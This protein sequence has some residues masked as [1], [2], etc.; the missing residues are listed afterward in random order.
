MAQINIKQ[1]RGGSQGSILFLGTNSVASEDINKLSWNQSTDIFSVTGNIQMVDGNQQ[2]GYVL[3]SDAQ[4]VGSWQP[5]YSTQSIFEVPISGTQNGT[6]RDFVLQSIITSPVNLFFINGQLVVE[7]VDYVI[8]G[9]ALSIDPDRPAPEPSDNLRVFGVISSFDSLGTSGTSGNNGTSGTSGIS[10]VAGATNGLSSYSGLIGIG[11]TFSQNTRIYADDFTFYIDSARS[12]GLTATEDLSTLVYGNLKS[13]GLTVDPANRVNVSLN[14]YGIGATSSLLSLTDN[15]ISLQSRPQGGAYSSI[16]NYN[17]SQ[18]AGDGSNNNTFLIIDSLN[19]KGLV[20][21]SDYSANFTTYSLVTK[22]YVDGLVSTGTSG[23]SGINGNDGTSGSSGESGTAGTSGVNGN[24]GTSGSSGQSGTAGTSGVNGNDGTSGSSGQSGTAGTS[25][26]NGN[27]GTSGS[28]GQSGTAGTSGINGNDGTSG[29]SGQSGTAGTSGTG[30]NTVSN[31]SDNRILTSDGT[32]NS[33]NA[34]SNLTFDG[35][36]LNVIGDLVVS[37]DFTIN[38]T[39]STIS[40]QN[41]LVEDPLILLASTQSGSPSL[42]SGIMINRGSGATQ[43]FIWDESMDEF[44]VI[45]TN[46][47]ASVQGNLTI[48]TYSNFRANQIQAERIK[49][50]DGAQGGYI[51]MSDPTGLAYWTASVPGTS[52]TSGVNGNDGTSGTSG[53]DGNAGT[54]GSSGQSGTAGTSGVNGNDG[55]SG[56][57]GESGTAGTSGINGNDGTSG[58]S[59]VNGNDGTSGS[60]GQSGTAGTSGINGNDGTSGSSG[61]SGTAGTSGING[62][63]GTSGSSGESGTAGTSGVNGNDGTSGSSG[64]SGTAG[65]SGFNGNDGTSGSSGQSGTSGSS[66]VNGNDGTSG[67]SAQS[68]TSGT[69]GVNGNDGTSG[70]SGQSGTA[71]TSGVNGNDGTS[72]S[73]GQSGTSGTSGESG[74]AGTSGTGFNTVSNASDNR[75]LTSDGTT[76]AA[77]AESNLTFDGSTLNVIGDLVVSGDFTIN[78][79]TSTIST[80]NLLVEDP[81]ILLASTQSGSPSLDSGIMINRGSGATQAFIWDESMDEFAVIQTND[82]ASVQGNLN[83]TT[84]SNFRA[85]QIQSERIKLTD[86]AQ[87][88]Y[89]LMSDTT[90]LAYWT[91]SIPG[92]SG[93]S[94]VNGND[95]TSGSSGESGTAG[96]SGVNGNDGTSG[97]S[98]ESGTAGTSGVNG[99]DGTAGTSGVNGND[100]TSG[101]SGESGTAGTSGVNGNDGT[102]GTSGVNGTA[103]T[104]GVNGTAG[105]AGTSGVNGNDGTSGSSGTSGTGFNTI[106]NPLNNRIL[107]S[108]GAT[109]SANAEEN[110]TFDGLLLSVTG[111]VN[112][113]GNLIIGDQTFAQD[114]SFAGGQLSTANGL[115]SAAFGFNTLA[116]STYSFVSGLETIA[117][118]EGQFVV[119]KYNTDLNYDDL[120]VIGNGLGNTERSD[121]AKFGTNSITFN[122]GLKL[123]YIDFSTQSVTSISRR[124]FWDVDNNTVSIG[125]SDDVTQQVGQEM[126]YQVKNQTGGTLSSGRVVAAAGTVGNSGRILVDY[127]IADGSIPNKYVMGVLT[128]DLI[129]GQDGFVTEFGLVRQIDTTGSSFGETW[130]NGDILWLSD[131]TPGGLTKFE[132]EAPSL[133]ILIALV[134]NANANGSIFVR[135]TLGEKLS[136]LHDVEYING[137]PS[138]GDFLKWN[139]ISERWE[140]TEFNE[141]AFSAGIISGATAWS[142]PFTGQLVLPTVEVALYD[143]PNFLGNLRIYDVLGATTGTSGIPSLVDNETN[144]I[145]I[146]YNS[147]TP[148][149]DVSNTDSIINGSD[150]VRFMT[151]YRLGTFVHTLEFGNIGAGLSEKLNARTIATERFARES[152]LTIGLSGSTGIATITDGIAWNGPFRQE[153]AAVNSVDDFMF[154]NWRVSGNWTYSVGTPF[155]FATA[156]DLINNTFY[157]NGDLITASAGYYLTNYYYRGQEINDHIYEVF[158][159]DQ[160]D[161]FA[162]AQLAGIPSVPELISSHAVLVGRIIVEVGTFSGVAESSFVTAFQSS[163]VTSHND[164]NGIQGGQVGEFYHLSESEYNNNAYKNVDN[165]FTTNQTVNGYELKTETWTES[166][167]LIAGTNSVLGSGYTFNDGVTSSNTIWS[168]EYTVDYI[169]RPTIDGDKTF[170]NNI[171]INGNLQ[172]NGT[173][174]VGTNSQFFGDLLPSQT[175]TFNL[176]SPSLEWDKLYVASQSIYV[177]GV[178]ISSD[179]DA[180]NIQRINFGTEEQPI[181]LSGNLGELLLNGRTFSE[182]NM[183]VI[184]VANSGG[185]FTSVKAAMESITTASDSNPFVISVCAGTYLEDP[186]TVKSHVAILGESSQSTII[187][188]TDPNVNFLTCQDQSFISD[189]Q[190]TGATGVSASAVYYSS[191]TTT[192]SQAIVYVENVRFGSN[193]NHATVKPIGSGNIAMQLT[194]V[195]Y[196]A[197]PFTLG[198]YAT[199]NGTGVCRMLLRNVTTTAG[200]IQSTTGLVFAKTDQ[201]NCTIIANLVG[202]TKVGSG[203]A[204]GVGFQAENGGLLRINVANLQRFE[205]AIYIPSGGAAPTI[206]AV[207]LNF[208]NCTTD[209][210]ILNTSTLGKI[211]GISDYTKTIIPVQ[212][213]VYIVGKDQRRITVAKK[214]GDFSS[215]KSAV[216]S[217]SG[218]SET[219][220]YVIEIGPGEFYEE[221]IDLSTKPYV[222]I[223]GSNIQTTQIFASA[224]NQ[225]LFKMGI[226]NEISFLSLN[227]VGVGYAAILADDSGDFSQAHKVSFYNCDIGIKILSLTND[228][229]FYG[230]YVDFNGTFS[231]AVCVDSQDSGFLAFANIENFYCFPG[232]TGSMAGCVYNVGA[233]L[234]VSISTLEGAGNDVAFYLEN[235]GKL[236][237]TATDIVGYETGIWVPN[238]GTASNFDFSAVTMDDN[239]SIPLKI[240]QPFTRGFFQGSAFNHNL[241]QNASEDVYWNFLDR[242]DGELNITRKASVTFID[243]TTTDLTTL[244]F[245]TAPMGVIEGG[246][247]SIVSGVTISVDAGYG[248]LMTSSGDVHKRIDW[249]TSEI[250]L[251]TNNSEYIYINENEILTFGA[252]LPDIETNILLGRVVTYNGSVLFIDNT[253]VDTRHA[254]NKLNLFNRKAIGAIYESGSLVTEGST[255]SVLD[256][257]QG[258]YW[259][260]ESNFTPS[261][262]LTVSFNQVYRDGFG[263]WIISSTTSVTG[264][265]DNDSGSLITMSASYYTKHTLYVVGEGVDERYLLVV[266]QT[267]YLNLVD[268]EDAALPT[269]PS[270]F[271]DG[272]AAIA[273]IYVQEGTL[274]IL[275][276]EDIRPVLGF[277]SSGV[278]AT[279]DHGNLLGLSDDDHPQYLL[280]DGARPMVG[281]LQMGSN[282]ITGVGQVNGVTVQSHASRH[283]PN[284]ADPLATGVPSTVGTTNTEG[285]ANAFARQDHV[286]AHGNQLGGLLHATASATQA[287]FMSAA[288]K[289]I[290]DDIPQTYVNVSGDTM[291][292]VLTMSSNK[293]VEVATA[294]N[295]LDATNLGQ[296]TKLGAFDNFIYI[297]DYTDFG[298]SSSGVYTLSDNKTYFITTTVDLLGGRLVSGQNTTILGGSSENCRIK[299]TG[300]TSGVPLISSSYSI[301]MRGLTLEANTALNLNPGTVSAGQAIDWFGVNF[302]NCPQVGTISNYTNFIANDCALLNSSELAFEGT[303]NT[304]GFDQCLFSGRAGQRTIIIPPTANIT[305]RFRTIYSSFVAFGGAI[306]LDV[307]PTAS[308]PNEGYILDTINFS[309]G[310]TYVSGVDSTSNKSLFINCVGITNSSTVGSY[311]TLNNTL[312]TSVSLNTWS[313]ATAS[314]TPIEVSK[315]DHVDNRLTYSGVRSLRFKVSAIASISWAGGGNNKDIGIGIVKNGDTTLVISESITRAV[316]S[317]VLYNIT[318]QDIFSLASGDFIEVYVIPRSSTV[319]SITVNSLSL[320]VTEI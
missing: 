168:S 16:V 220:R 152:G 125:M 268:A 189:I 263:G 175:D 260:G 188:T 192:A 26:I 314:T 296:V 218:T 99:N 318:S 144:Y 292:G 14:N 13:G 206:D 275:Q 89:I 147:G 209:V 182:I 95:G 109:N 61:Q 320:I 36:T 128:Q 62:N 300:L 271:E 35:S 100:G 242:F 172:V 75:I 117:S 163:S 15:A 33:A 257:S 5:G 305:R 291:V 92:T 104:S 90:G 165:Q 201:P 184:R 176:G 276:I 135:P 137:T 53:V 119:G 112:I 25:G 115:A 306:A 20:Y 212:A 253:R 44:A 150:K 265:Y 87:D 148:I 157:D 310:A 230:E 48:S 73:S 10:G 299:S 158:S 106:T 277:K 34:E 127:A 200:G 281:N 197:Q 311:Y 29:S 225:N 215:V 258:S 313:R 63:D 65:T 21:N 67:S 267:Q 131:S 178:T 81:L 23:T 107:T 264:Q 72:G 213:P 294:S 3:V 308:I 82:S 98:G 274:G 243:G 287:G 76:N 141:G 232:L 6:N 164:L 7:N 222:S 245:E 142:Q 136:D 187:Q 40:T 226:A 223:V 126:Y 199:S 288:D 12:I 228:T 171:L 221:E 85:N 47:S 18:T 249:A 132:P 39:T 120:F 27:D 116:S 56:S 238:I 254:D 270:Y 50:T 124:V 59:G 52:G 77:N 262:G 129:D 190:I 114:L 247:I 170:S 283:L 43:A 19:S 269:P 97:S 193:W 307:S 30:F 273:S 80:Q 248:Y 37:G 9:T 143:N 41:L 108:D 233:E 216:D 57:S 295:D 244:V 55:T 179:T 42:D 214:G 103:G 266:G 54:S 191:S 289:V 156:T 229:L 234:N 153:L 79:T 105:T 181:I 49:I 22:Q 261:G 17:T 239:V 146:D 113:E 290:F 207:G 121:L 123:D 28:S 24:D 69:S 169:D 315:F 155:T 235:G 302:T 139:S 237:V 293:I 203:P 272:V 205:K 96:T 133:K 195:K 78:G 180:I 84:Y 149:W 211:D 102:A 303:I 118:G 236:N 217:L 11:G 259:F 297:S 285:T 250:A 280:V 210:E 278:N 316:T 110:L 186:F 241:I 160:Y 286:H 45:Q 319:T 167:I 162:S 159:Q 279:S 8:S 298:A 138:G 32:A 140:T 208:E 151:V 161:T 317:G 231:Q 202:L 51:L 174:S 185:Q 94:G 88:G 64:Q 256:V 240:E 60:S 31:A 194:N 219:N 86:G 38:G 4:G 93:T 122:S 196:G 177:G 173:F 312:A 70:S 301:P 83:I 251:P 58:S 166:N 309:G 246:V 304:V 101:S 46:D 68:G 134:I 74:T 154:K 255:Y 71:G 145:Y 284:G 66:G 227:D 252:S 224:S 91:A 282:S 1:I 2:T 111:D 130:S 183:N 204:Q 198:F